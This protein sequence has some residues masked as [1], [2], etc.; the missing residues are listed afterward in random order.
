MVDTK[1]L[2]KIKE[3]DR[4][5]LFEHKNTGIK[6]CILKTDLISGTNVKRK[7]ER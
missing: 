3:Y 5:V 4:F 1:D 6:E 7:L 2:I